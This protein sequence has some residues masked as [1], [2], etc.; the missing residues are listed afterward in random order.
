[1][2]TEDLLPMLQAVRSRGADRWS[3]RCPAHNDHSP[4]LSIRKGEKGI[5]LHCFAGCDLASIC[6]SL[7]IRPRDLFYDVSASVNHHA[8]RRH[9]ARQQVSRIRQQ[10]EGRRVDALREA[11]AVIRAASS[12]DMSTWSDAQV[13]VAL[14]CVCDAHILL[15]REETH[16]THKEHAPA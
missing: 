14:N 10:A 7:G 3:V 12:I 9:R 5:L 11:E 8:I 2:T 1:M 16:A 13:D 4:S 15:L 6:T